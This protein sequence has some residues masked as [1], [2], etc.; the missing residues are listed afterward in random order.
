MAC[1]ANDGTTNHGSQSKE[2]QER[3]GVDAACD[4]RL[5]VD[6]LEINGKIEPNQEKGGIGA[7]QGI[8]S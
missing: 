6:R 5:V 7:W 3:E 4:G 8:A 1:L 2:G